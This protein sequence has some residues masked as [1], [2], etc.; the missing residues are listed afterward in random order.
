MAPSN[1][2]LKHQAEDSRDLFKKTGEKTPNDNIVYMVPIWAIIMDVDALQP[3]D[4]RHPSSSGHYA[5]RD[6]VVQLCKPLL[7]PKKD[8]EPIIIT[9][10][11]KPVS[12]ATNVLPNTSTCW[13]VIDG[14]HRIMAYRRSKSRDYIPAVIFD[15]PPI[16]AVLLAIKCN[17]KN[18][19]S[20][21]S[22]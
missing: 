9:R 13:T 6:H 15:G 1:H 11:I 8:L 16:D 12:S 17:N 18:K 7:N 3:R 19:R 2:N 5:S 21:T 10:T 4:D 14:H 22:Q 20:M